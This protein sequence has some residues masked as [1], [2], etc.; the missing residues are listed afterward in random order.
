MPDKNEENFSGSFKEKILQQ[1]EADKQKE[2]QD[3]PTVQELVRSRKNKSNDIKEN[4]Q[5]KANSSISTND[6]QNSTDESIKTTR[7]RRSENQDVSKKKPKQK[8]G[9]IIAFIVLLLLVLAGWLGYS[10]VDSNVKPVDPTNHTAQIVQIPEGSST[11]QIANILKK[12]GLIKSPTVFE[13][14]AKF[15]N[16]NSFK[17]GS[18]SLSPDMN[19]SKIANILQGLAVVQ[20]GKI[21]IPEGYTIAQMS[22]A[23]TMD[24]SNKNQTTAISSA[25]FMKAVQDKTFISKM[26][27]E[28]PD[29]L[30]S[31][32]DKSTGV[33]YQLE[34]YLFPATY[35]YDGSTT[36][37][38]LIEKMLAATDA[39]L[40]PYYAQIKSQNLSVNQVLSLAA[41]IEREA[42]TETDRQNVAGVFFNRIAQ[43]MPLQSNPSILY[44]QGRLGT[45][46]TLEQDANLDTKFDSPY[47]LYIHTGTGPGP[48]DNPSLSSIE[49]VIKP[50]QNSYLYFV[51]DVKTGKVYFAE[52]YEEQQ[53]NVQQ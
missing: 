32:P 4:N 28:F 6:K 7:S 29:L 42:N 26:K 34:G 50:A 25:D 22:T 46:T 2:E 53:A 47:N 12:D 15:K 49:A 21:M 24:A 1:I 13:W 52:T 43:G 51:A 10:Y 40:K 37:Q 9:K 35:D 27:A 48:I 5:E 23:V 44:A 39:N 38:I 31:L 30:A 36:A 41:L 33:K 14:Y 8:R 3:E 20:S 19:L 18:Y 16:Y 11:K 17:G 45:G